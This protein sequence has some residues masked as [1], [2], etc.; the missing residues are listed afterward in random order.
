MTYYG[1]VKTINISTFKAKISEH[2]RSVRRGEKIIITDREHPIATVSPVE[3]EP[4]PI[5]QVPKGT[6]S[7]PKLSFKVSKDPL[8]FLMEDRS[9]R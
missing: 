6:L 1:P 7:F 4:E 3:P 9:K 8:D 2:L 5:I